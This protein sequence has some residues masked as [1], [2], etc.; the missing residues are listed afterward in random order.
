MSKATRLSNR[1]KSE[2]LSF[3]IYTQYFIAA[4]KATR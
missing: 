2:L 3:T 1:R 4:V